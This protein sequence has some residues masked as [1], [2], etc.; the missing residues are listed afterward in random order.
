MPKNNQKYDIQVTR[1]LKRPT[2]RKNQYGNSE[3]ETVGSPSVK[4]LKN[5]NFTNLKKNL[6]EQSK[7]SNNVYVSYGK[8]TYRITKVRPRVKSVTVRY[9]NGDKQ[10]SYY[11]AVGKN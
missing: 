1:Y 5:T 11:K 6:Y 8:P 10:V 4:V 2:G 3:Y 7:K 9:A